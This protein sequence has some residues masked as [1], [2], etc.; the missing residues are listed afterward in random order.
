MDVLDGTTFV[1]LLQA[2]EVT[3]L[4]WIPD[5]TLGGWNEAVENCTSLDVIRPAREGEALAI[6]AGLWIAGKRPFVAIQCTGFYEAGDA[7]RNVIHDLKI[8]LWILVGI[9]SYFAR[10][11]DS[12]ATFAKPIAEAWDLPYTLIDK[13]EQVPTLAETLRT[14]AANHQPH[15]VLLAE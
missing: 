11:Q 10:N 5:S 13:S 6:A 9:R 14:T 15:L 7:L 2:I 12:A 8:P 4:A 1:A 3:H